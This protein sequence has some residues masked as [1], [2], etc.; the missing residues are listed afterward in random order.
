MADD[1]HFRQTVAA[2]PFG[3]AYIRVGDSPGCATPAQTIGLPANPFTCCCMIFGCMPNDGTSRKFFPSTLAFTA[4]FLGSCPQ[5]QGS[6]IISGTLTYVPPPYFC[7]D[8]TTHGCVVW[9]TYLC[10]GTYAWTINPGDVPSC[11]PYLSS[12]GINC[13]SPPPGFNP[14]A[15][16]AHMQPPDRQC[17]L[18]AGMVLSRYSKVRPAKDCLCG[19]I[20]DDGS[21]VCTWYYY[22]ADCNLQVGGTYNNSGPPPCPPGTTAQGCVC[23]TTSCPPCITQCATTDRVCQPLVQC[24][25]TWPPGCGAVVATTDPV[26]DDPGCPDYCPGTGQNALVYSLALCQCGPGDIRGCNQKSCGATEDDWG[27]FAVRF[28][29]CPLYDELEPPHF[30]GCVGMTTNDYL[31]VYCGADVF[32]SMAH[33]AEM[34]KAGELHWVSSGP[35]DPVVTHPEPRRFK[36]CRHKTHRPNCV[37]C[38]DCEHNALYRKGMDMHV[39]N[40]VVGNDVG[41]IWVPPMYSGPGTEYKALTDLLELHEWEGCGCRA[42]QNEMDVLGSTGCRAQR[43]GL[44]AKI[45]ANF[46]RGVASGKI[47]KDE[48]WERA[49]RN[50]LKHLK[51]H[52]RFSTWLDPVG[53]LF[54]LAVKRAAKNERRARAEKEKAAAGRAASGGPA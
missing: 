13:I 23:C 30:L 7:A 9:T 48:Y 41:Q 31:D 2:T 49:K 27:G 45:K 22:D 10:G 47:D 52:M 38:H 21:R 40:G 32:E 25:S 33:M 20:Q 46:E 28:L 37:F 36:P 17:M 3:Q 4:S 12:A 1:P 34:V 24:C 53:W 16:C 26:D 11:G 54:D 8:I 6:G 43:A 42:I 15:N 35:D 18:A 44:V 5:A 14:I 19:A 39:L 50:A 51:R 29:Q